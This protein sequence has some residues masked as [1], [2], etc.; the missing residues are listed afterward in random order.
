MGTFVTTDQSA[1]VK[2]EHCCNT[3]FVEGI[4]HERA[5]LVFA[6]VRFSNGAGAVCET[7]IPPPSATTT[8]ILPSADEATEDH[9]VWGALFDV[10]V[11][12]E[13]VE[14]KMLLQSTATNL[15]PSAEEATECHNATAPK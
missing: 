15:L 14:V 1:A 10:Q 13:F 9:K 8:N 7:Q 12:P 6:V 3:K 4:I 5:R 2:S 11:S